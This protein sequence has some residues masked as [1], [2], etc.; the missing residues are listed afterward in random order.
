MIYKA[1]YISETNEARLEVQFASEEASDYVI[2][3]DDQYWTIT[4]I[5]GESLTMDKTSVSLNQ[6]T[7]LFAT[8]E[9]LREAARE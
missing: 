4:N 8:V 7:I 2:E 9:G 1:W 6:L 5:D 3:E